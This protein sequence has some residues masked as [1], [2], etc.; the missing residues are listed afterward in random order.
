MR[1]RRKDYKTKF[2]DHAASSSDNKIDK[3]AFRSVLTKLGVGID[4]TLFEENFV[5]IWDKDKSGAITEDEFVAFCKLQFDNNQRKEVVFK[6]MKNEDQFRR[7]IDS[8]KENELD[9]KYVVDIIRTFNGDEDTS[10]LSALESNNLGEYK[11]AILMPCADRNLDNIFRSERP[12]INATR[13][14]A[15]QAAEAI[16]HIHEQGII[17]GDLKML[18]LVR[19]NNRLFLIDFDA[20]APLN[21]DDEL[22]EERP[23]SEDDDSVKFYAGAKFSSGVLPPEMI[24]KLTSSKEIEQFDSYFSSVCAHDKE[25]YSKI[26][27]RVY[28]QGKKRAMNFVVKTFQT[29]LVDMGDEYEGK[30][31]QPVSPSK[32]PYS[33]IKASPAIDL[34]SFGTVLYALCSGSNLISVNRDDD[35]DGGLA[36]HELYNWNDA[37][38]IEKLKLVDDPL[39]REL[40]SKLLSADIDNRPQTMQEVVDD[41]FFTMRYRGSSYVDNSAVLQEI[42]DL[43]NSLNEKFENEKKAL[44]RLEVG[45]KQVLENTIELKNMSKATMGED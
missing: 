2:R 21:E 34:W 27:P 20:S 37:K 42:A 38:K 11:Y 9:S 4:D 25:L 36:M 15:R 26:Q 33:L 16:C 1:G 17:H 32:L 19:F 30:L 41:D 10:F 7:E 35:L 8:R 6:F 12:G 22:A 40:L 3:S 31:E 23:K 28:K 5:N 13:E 45:Q 18:N 14:L 44:A 24:S 29:E 39:A 43:K